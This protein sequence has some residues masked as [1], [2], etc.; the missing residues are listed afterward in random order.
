MRRWHS[1]RGEGNIGCIL[2]VLV[3]ILVVMVAWKAIPAKLSTTKLYDYMD[4]LAK[5]NAA[6]KPPDELK[7]MILNRAK[8]LDITVDPNNVV[9]ARKGDSIHMDI[10]YQMPVTVLGFTYQ[11]NFHQTLDRP[12]F[13]I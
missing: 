4:E 8:D 3:L 10:Q 6:S 13:I 7:K 9:V 5:F 1:E 12:I 2:W 11:W